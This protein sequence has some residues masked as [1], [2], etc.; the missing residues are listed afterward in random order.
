MANKGV[1]EKALPVHGLD[2]LLYTYWLLY[3]CC[4]RLLPLPFAVRHAFVCPMELVKLREKREKW[5][6]TQQRSLDCVAGVEGDALF[7][8][9]TYFRR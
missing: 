2:W 7:C 8:F 4:S 9:K 1:S 3:V 6:V 5:R